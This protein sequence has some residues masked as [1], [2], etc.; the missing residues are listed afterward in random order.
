MPAHALPWRPVLLAAALLAGLGLNLG[1]LPLFD[2]DEGAFSEAT[3]EMFVRGDFLS[4]SLYGAPRWD[5]PI[6]IYWLQAASTRVLGFTELGFR[7]PS[8]L[9]ALGW[10]GI[11]YYYVR[12]FAGREAAWNA[13]LLL[14][15]TLQV[16]LIARAAIADSLL[17]L[18]LTAA[19]LATYAYWREGRRRDLYAASLAMALGFLTKGP[20]ALLIPLAVSFLFYAGRRRLRDWWRLVTDLRAVALF[21]GVAGPWYAYQLWTHGW[22]FVEGFFLQHNLRRFQGPLEGHAGSL[23]YYLPVVLVGLLPHT[24][25]WLQ[26]L[27][28]LGGDR[29]DPWRLYLWLWFGFV[30]A[31]FSLS[32][33]KL[34]HYVIYGYPALMALMAAGLP[35]WRGRGLLLLSPLIALFGFWLLVPGLLDWLAP[36]VTDPFARDVLAGAGTEFGTGYRLAAALGLAS[37]AAAAL[38]PRWPAWG[39]LGAGGVV[40]LAFLWGAF[41]PALARVLQEPVREAA[42]LARAQ[43]LEVVMWRINAPSFLVYSGRQVVRRR[44]RPGEVVL[45]KRIH[46][47]EL[48]PY[49]PLLLRHGIALVRL[50]KADKAPRSDS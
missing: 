8:V 21:L 28:R 13:A 39:R 38:V 15:T 18:C 31:F 36:R 19:M 48:G 25:L 10:V 40:M 29:E 34:P 11:L 9:A 23:L 41:A 44:P 3:R 46:L 22:A 5:K 50:G 26:R 32:G 47:D 1:S 35:A 12:R 20:V 42:R 49:R 7:L 14:A 2:L 24:V 6:L 45:T 27:A 43:D 17:N 33:T 37:V 4:T 16:S 30:F